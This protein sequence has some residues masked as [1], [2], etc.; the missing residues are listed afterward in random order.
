MTLRFLAE[1]PA[2]AEAQRLQA[3]VAAHA[4][5]FLLRPA[6]KLLHELPMHSA[7]PRGDLP[8]AEDQV[9]RLVNLPSSPQLVI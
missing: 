2:A 1:D 6:W 9:R 3:L 8:V 4:T 7:A 5:G